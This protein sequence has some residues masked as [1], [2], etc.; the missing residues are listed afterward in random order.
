MAFT[1]FTE[2]DQPTMENFN[3]KFQEVLDSGV[4]VEAGSYVGTGAFGSGN[5][6]SLTF[7]FDPD[8][9]FIGGSI[10][11]PAT[12]VK[13]A[14]VSVFGSTSFSG[15]TMHNGKL[16]VTWGNNSVS[17]Y[18]NSYSQ[19]ADNQFNISGTTYNYVAI[20]KEE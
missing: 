1:P 4:K 11:G 15:N 14:S 17:W 19:S 16:I 8:L 12:L 2:Q 10:K 9:V 6:N 7:D 3:E 18:D 13:N 20:G 5:Q